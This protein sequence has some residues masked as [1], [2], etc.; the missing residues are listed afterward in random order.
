MRRGAAGGSAEAEDA[1]AIQRR[2]IGRREVLG[3]DDRLRR[4]LGRCAIATHEQMEHAPA[5]VAQIGGAAREQLGAERQ[6]PVRLLPVGLPP[7]VCRRGPLVGS[8]RR[9]RRVAR[10]P[11][12]APGAPRRSRPGRRPPPRPAAAAAPR[13]GGAR[14]AIAA[15]SARRSWLGSAA[16]SCRTSSVWRRWNTRPI[17][18]PGE[19]GTP[20][21]G[22]PG[23]PAGPAGTASRKSA[24]R[25]RGRDRPPRL[26]ARCGARRGEASACTT[27]AAAAAASSPRATTV[28]ASPLPTSSIMMDTTLRALASRP[29]LDQPNVGGEAARRRRD[30]RGGTRVQPPFARDHDRGRLDRA[31]LRRGDRLRLGRR[32][33]HLEERVPSSGDP[34]ASHLQAPRRDPCSPP[35]PA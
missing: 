4:D 11:R 16:R 35:A 25:G 14:A 34:A 12:A 33:T 18:T 23:V 13:A 6:E 32:E 19:A 27:A 3:H 8:A 22:P 10:D 1:G 24:A 20:V 9:R 28:T 30:R 7:R 5:H 21:S 17:A 31:A 26:A 2:G 15:S 29:L